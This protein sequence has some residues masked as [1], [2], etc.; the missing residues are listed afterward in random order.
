MELTVEKT[1]CPKP[2]P[3]D[4]SK[5]G[6]GKIFTDHMFLMNYT[7]G[8]GW[9]D[10]RIVPYA[11]FSMDPASMVLH[12]GQAI[13]EGLKAYRKP[14]GT[15]QLFRPMENL[16]RFNRSARRLCIPEID[17][18]FVY[19]CMKTLLKMEEDWVPKSPGTTLYIRP[20]AIAT[21]AALGVHVAESFLFSIILSP[22]GNYYAEGLKPVK[23]LVENEYVR[24]VRGGMGFAKAAGNYAVSLIADHTAHESG[25]AQVLWLDGVERKYVEEVGSMNIFFKIGGK[26]VTPALQGSILGG[27]T[28]MSVLELAPTLGC[29]VEERPIT[30]DEVYAAYKDGTLE[31]V[32]GSGTAAVISPV[33]ALIW[34]DE[35]IQVAD[36]QMGPCAGSIYKKLTDI[37]FGLC[38]DDMGWT[39]AL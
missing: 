32:F 26:L 28:R 10:A 18:D 15:V 11:P 4:E 7:E 6:F 29:E 12:Y 22:V 35:E 9:H 31:E 16:L 25:C 23:I 38:P 14:D 3:Q 8:R 33:G 24:A 37:Q 36:G 27:I 21:E 2:K 5:L 19:E 1:S 13:F 17:V 20:F 30:I 34:K 39:V